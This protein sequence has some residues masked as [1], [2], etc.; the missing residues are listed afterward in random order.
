MAKIRNV[1]VVVSP[2]KEGENPY[3]KGTHK[4]RLFQWAL[5]HGE[6]SKEQFLAAEKELFE[7]NDL[8]S[9]MTPDVRSKAWWNE[10][11]NKHHTFV[12]SAKELVA[13]TVSEEQS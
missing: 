1:L 10:F 11:F 6:F 8:T 7:Q 9:A 5:D 13:T 12:V 2:A 3:K 4:W